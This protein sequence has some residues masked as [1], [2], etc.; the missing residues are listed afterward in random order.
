MLFVSLVGGAGPGA[1]AAALGGAFVWWAFVPP[2][3]A[4]LSK[5]PNQLE[6]ALIYLCASL[7]IVWGADRYRKL[8]KQLEDE[9]NFR[10][11]AV[12]ELGHRL[13]NKIAT[14]QSIIRY[15]LRDDPPSRD[16][17]IGRLTALS[18]T[19]DLILAAQ[20]RG[21]QLRDILTAE[22][23]PYETSRIAMEGPAA[24]LGPKLALT[25]AML[26]HELAT[27]SAKYGALSSPSGKLSVHWS[28]SG[29]R[30]DLEWRESGGPVVDLPARRG[31]GMRLLA[32]ALDQFGGAVTTSFEPTG[33]VGKL[34]A[35]ISKE[36]DD[37][38]GSG[39]TAANS[40]V[41]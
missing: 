1:F 18:A 36:F 35:M 33:F 6:S 9:E 4:F 40:A 38:V 39:A 21:A 13:K 29:A 41:A 12:E 23:D 5:D 31:F 24:F 8:T 37:S 11:L 15:Q 28:L 32:S 2:Q 22:L 26:L 25:M 27:N 34:T 7:L 14:I 19:D 30:L 10:K 17:I 16:A 3:F 20:G